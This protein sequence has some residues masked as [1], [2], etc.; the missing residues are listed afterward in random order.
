MANHAVI[1]GVF[2]KLRSKPAQT[3]CKATPAR[4]RG[5]VASRWTAAAKLPSDKPLTCGSEG[6][7]PKQELERK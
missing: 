4:W 6:A 3:Q 7:Q 5:D 2:Q 1:I